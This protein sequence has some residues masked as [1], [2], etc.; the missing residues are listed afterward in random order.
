M[1]EDFI[2]HAQALSFVLQSKNMNELLANVQKA[3]K[4]I[5]KVVKVSFLFVDK[6]F[7][8]ILTHEGSRLK[9]MN[10]AYQ[11]F[12]VYVPPEVSKPHEMNFEFRFENMPDVIKGNV[13]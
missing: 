10:H 1:I 2:A 3:L 7:V 8:E 12:H 11:T 6:E 5:F 13:C 4:Q 9:Q